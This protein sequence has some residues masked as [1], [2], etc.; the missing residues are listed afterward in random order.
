MIPDQP[1]RKQTKTGADLVGLDADQELKAQ[2]LALLPARQASLVLEL[3]NLAGKILNDV[4]LRLSDIE[5]R[6]NR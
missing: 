5:R 1:N 3:T 4:E 2:L 6:L